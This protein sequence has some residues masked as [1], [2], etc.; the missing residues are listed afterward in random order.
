MSFDEKV[1]NDGWLRPLVFH[2]ILLVELEGQPIAFELV[3]IGNLIFFLLRYFE[4]LDLVNHETE[5]KIMFAWQTPFTRREG[6]YNRDGVESRVRL[7]HG[8]D[9]ANNENEVRWIHRDDEVI[10]EAKSIFVFKLLENVAI[11]KQADELLHLLFF[12]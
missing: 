7:M 6:T 5:E 4:A 12:L 10:W 9:L 11:V 8:V 2:K 1:S 3:G